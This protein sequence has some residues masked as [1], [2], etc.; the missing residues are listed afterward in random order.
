MKSSVTRK[1]GIAIILVLTSLALIVPSIAIL[2]GIYQSINTPNTITIDPS[3][4]TI[5]TMAP[6][7]SV[8][9]VSPAVSPQA[10]PSEMGAPVIEATPL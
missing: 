3:Q 5:T 7:V 10:M 1:I 2:V 6:S 4:V 8:S 9:A